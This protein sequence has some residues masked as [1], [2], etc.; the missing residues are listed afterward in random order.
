MLEIEEIKAVPYTLVSHPFV[1]RLIGTIWREYLDRVF[2]WNASD[3][4]CKLDEFKHY[5]DAARVYR[6]L[7]G[8]HTDRT[9]CR[10]LLHSRCLDQ[11]GWQQPCRGLLQVPIPLD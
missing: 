9:G 8:K 10:P 6:G 11:Y 5:Y 2:F 7:T 4:V 1:E 3:L